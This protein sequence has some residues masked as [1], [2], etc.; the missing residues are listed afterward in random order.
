MRYFSTAAACLLAIIFT[1]VAVAETDAKIEGPTDNADKGVKMFTI[2]S[3]F[4]GAPSPIE[5]LLP[6]KIDPARKYRTVYILP[7]QGGIGGQWGDAIAEFRKANVHN[8]HDVICVFVAF[9]KAA[10][11][12]GSHVSNP[13]IRHDR[14]L[15]EVVVPLIER[16]FPASSEPADRLLVGF[17][18]SGWGVASLLLRNLDFFGA[19]CSWDAPLMMTE[20]K[21]MFGSK[22]HFGDPEHA[23]DYVPATLVKKH[24]SELAGGPPRLTIVGSNRFGGETRKF[25]ELLD[26]Q[27]VPHR[28]SNDVKFDHHWE[29]GWVAPAMDIFLGGETSTKAGAAE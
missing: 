8:R 18:K 27:K 11:W 16:E 10:T 23:A 13:R 6:D 21:L 22:N 5:V 4:I 7:V 15:K 3:E 25:H 1:N 19:A 26:E 17:S 28:F 12:G 24:A 9:D 20:A 2:E 14:H 29:S